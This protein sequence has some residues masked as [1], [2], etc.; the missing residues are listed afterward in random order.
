MKRGRVISIMLT[1]SMKQP[2]SSRISSMTISTDQG[3]R[4][5]PWT[6]ATRPLVA[7]ENARICE[8]VVAPMMMNRMM[9]EMAAVPISALS[10]LSQL[11]ER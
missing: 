10:R 2:S 9:P 11:S 4:P 7:P 1:W 8:N 3:D 5:P 6:S